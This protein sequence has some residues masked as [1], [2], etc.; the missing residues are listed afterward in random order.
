MEAA[1]DAEVEAKVET[2]DAKVNGA[3]AKVNGAGTSNGEATAG[4]E[5]DDEEDEDFQDG[6]EE[7][8]AVSCSFR[9]LI[10][11]RGVTSQ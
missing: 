7:E 2:A 5:E 8:S 3:D 9:G 1:E 11:T 4:T 6:D 10:S